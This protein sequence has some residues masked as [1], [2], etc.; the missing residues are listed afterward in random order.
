MSFVYTYYIA[1]N[2]VPNDVVSVDK[3]TAYYGPKTEDFSAD[4][5]GNP[6]VDGAFYYNTR[7]ASVRFYN[8]SSATWKTL[9]PGVSAMN[10]GSRPPSPNYGQTI[11]NSDTGHLEIWDGYAWD[12][13]F[14]DGVAAL[15]LLTNTARNANLFGNPQNGVLAVSPDA[16]TNVITGALWSQNTSYALN[17]IACT[18]SGSGASQIV[19]FYKCTTPGTSL[20]SGNGPSGTGG[21]IADNTVV[22][23]YQ[24][25]GNSRNFGGNTNAAL[26]SY[27]WNG[28]N[29]AGKA[30]PGGVVQMTGGI[31]TNSAG[32][33]Y[34]GV[35]V[36]H[37][38][39]P[40]QLVTV[41]GRIRFMTDSVSCI[42]RH[43]PG[44]SNNAF[45]V[46][47]NRKYVGSGTPTVFTQVKSN[48]SWIQL[49]FS[50]QSLREIEIEWETNSYF[51]G[52]DVAVTEKVYPLNDAPNPTIIWTGDSYA[53][54]GG[55]SNPFTGFSLATADWLGSKNMCNTA[56]GGDGYL[57]SSFPGATGTARQRLADLFQHVAYFPHP[58]II[59]EN[60]G[61]DTP[62]FSGAQIQAECT[63]YMKAIRAAYPTVPIFSTMRMNTNTS[64]S[65][66]TTV[67][68][69]KIAAIQSMN[70]PLIFY[71][72][73]FTAIDSPWLTGT[74]RDSA[75]DGTGNADIYI[76]GSQYD[77]PND[78]GHALI[79]RLLSRKIRNI[80]DTAGY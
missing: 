25:Q 9:I 70:D 49:T 30:A 65:N 31:P 78:A 41:M 76:S 71:I 28:G 29:S 23:A 19:F 15:R 44:A 56:I 42:I 33:G 3:L 14:V 4:V 69:A 34:G 50:T 5:T 55:T 13:T 45:R 59:D 21:S 39:N 2:I 38:L 57:V 32:T 16:P 37:F 80:L 36:V 62:T 27:M 73:V 79:A 12:T 47:V 6:V 68:N 61:N 43:F 66:Y 53:A 72:P 52:I 18:I 1:N 54:N 63:A 8:S 67:E 74:G 48:W 20:G 40:N 60:G 77:H 17:E 75:P 35:R 22:W 11:Y 24:T 7:S 46:L 51:G 58:I 10:T 64:L 26:N